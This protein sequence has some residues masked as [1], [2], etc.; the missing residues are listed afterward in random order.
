VTFRDR[1]GEQLSQTLGDRFAARLGELR[2]ELETR[3]NRPVG[4]WLS[5]STV[6]TRLEP[7]DD[8]QPA[9][10]GDELLLPL[11]LEG[12]TRLVAPP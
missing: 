3:L 10:V 7:P 9:V 4:E 5:L 6:I 11:R 2:R 1:L 12:T 8:Q